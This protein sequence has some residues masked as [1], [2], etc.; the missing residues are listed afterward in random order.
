M[1]IKERTQSKQGPHKKILVLMNSSPKDEIENILQNKNSED[2]KI[3][4]DSAAV[5]ELI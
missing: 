2:G 1:L 5:N 4:L 3:T